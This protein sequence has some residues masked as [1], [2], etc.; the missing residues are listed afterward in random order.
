MKAAH[1]GQLFRKYFS[2]ILALVCGA[3]V[4]SGGVGLYFAYQENK[5]ALMDLQREKAAGA[6]AR[7]EQFVGQ[8]EQQL[9]FAALPVL[10]PEG[11]EQRRIEFLRLLQVA[12]A[13]TDVAQ[14]DGKGREQLTVSRLK[15]N[16]TGSNEDR[17]QE[18][19]FKNA[20]PGQIWFGPVYFRQETEPYM[21][22]AVRSGNERGPV[23]VAEVNLK[24]IW[25]VVSRIRIGEKGKAYVIDATGYLI[26][27]PDIGLVLRKTRLA[28]LE[29]VKAAFA[30]GAD[31]SFAMLAKDAAGKEVLSASAPIEPAREQAGRTRKASPLGWKVFVEQPASE[32]YAALDAT[33]LRTVALIV[34]GLL[35]SALAALYL[36][37]SMVRPI[38]VLQ[39]GAQRIGA[40]DLE[41]K[42]EVRTGDELEALAGQFN[43]MTEQ[44]RDSYAG[45]E[46]KVDE[47]TAELQQTLE[48][49]TATSEILKVISGATTDVQ[50]VFEAIVQSAARLFV[51]W[52]V[53]IVMKDG[54]VLRRPAYAGPRVLTAAEQA[55]LER[56][57]PLPFDPDKIWIARAIAEGRPY[58]VPDTETAGML[59]LAARAR[60]GKYRATV[61][62]PL[63]REREGIGCIGILRE[64]PGYFSDK[65]VAL[66]QTFA[67]QAVIAIENARLFN[68]TK[69]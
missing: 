38:G 18:P 21:T 53:S 57:W 54:D 15:M 23:T 32:V 64:T 30:P 27:D 39:E 45:L 5:Q 66:A 24:F 22:M 1:R 26:A 17:S 31:E 43:R 49:Q 37:R 35:F 13:V 2:L 58:E 65:E 28:D 51:P 62:I 41:Q 60:I 3:I 55:D 29:Q 68:E 25:D 34:G 12:P 59:G 67:D 52:N 20:R 42:I 11:L 9:A 14:L 50:P 48:Q 36:A 10:G 19:G 47:R 61:V 6:A 44:L 69:E 56:M 40:G 16:T 7:I 4:I 46:R 33:I 8:I 63:I